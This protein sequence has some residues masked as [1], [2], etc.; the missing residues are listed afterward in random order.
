MQE[1]LQDTA[2]KVVVLDSQGH[3]FE[4]EHLHRLPPEVVGQ[5]LAVYNT[6]V[7]KWDCG[8]DA[9]QRLVDAFGEETANDDDAR[10]GDMDH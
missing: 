2:I 1:T 4:T 10:M 6:E 5:A 9:F 8:G 3:M 7:R